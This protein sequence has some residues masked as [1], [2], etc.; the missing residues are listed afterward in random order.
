MRGRGFALSIGGRRFGATHSRVGQQ[1]GADTHRHRGGPEPTSVHCV[2]HRAPFDVC[3]GAKSYGRNGLQRSNTE[4]FLRLVR[5]ATLVR[6]LHAFSES[7]ST[8]SPEPTERSFSERVY[9]GRARPFAAQVRAGSAGPAAD[10]VRNRSAVSANLC[11]HCRCSSMAEHQLPKLNTRVRF[12]SSALTMQFRACAEICPQS[13]RQNPVLS[14]HIRSLGL[15]AGPSL[16]HCA[17]IR[18]RRH[19]LRVVPLGSGQLRVQS[20]RCAA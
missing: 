20:C 1:R 11:V 9:S 16:Q 19:S 3:G 7:R 14:S 5:A 8:R 13:R 4:R 2:L 10:I 18:S 15:V 12:P 17:G 6:R